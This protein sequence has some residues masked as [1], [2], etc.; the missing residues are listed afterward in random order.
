MKNGNVPRLLNSTD[1]D[2]QPNDPQ[3]L[4]SPI[5]DF[6]NDGIPDMAISGIYELPSSKNRY[7]LLVG[8]QFEKPLRY[9]RMYFKE[10]DKPVFLHKPGTTGEKDSGDQCFSVTFCAEC[11]DG[12]DFY[13]SPKTHS[14]D[15]RPWEKRFRRY[16]HVSYMPAEREV[17][18]EMVDRALKVVGNLDDVKI[19]VA[20][21]KKSGKKLGTRVRAVSNEAEPADP[22]APIQTV[23]VE[24]FEKKKDAEK[25]YDEVTV[26]VTKDVVVSRKTK[27]RS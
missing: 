11:T 15:E 19:F 4:F 7:F 24:I 18:D 13:W 5:G 26:D 14:F 3:P 23:T 25:L 17:P 8:T 16:T 10:F 2:L 9:E 21:L 20:G 27:G 6:N 1:I 22:N 12:I